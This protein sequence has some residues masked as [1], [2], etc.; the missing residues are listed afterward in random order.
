MHFDYQDQYLTIDDMVVRYWDQ[1]CGQPLLLV[2]GLG[3]CLET[4]AWNIQA[5]SAERRVIALDLPGCG[6][7]SRLLRDDIF[8]LEYAGEFLCRFAES[9]DISSLAVAGNSMGGMLAMQ[10]ALAHPEMVRLLILISS[11]GLGR[12]VHWLIGVMSVPMLERIFAHP[13]SRVVRQVALK[14]LLRQD[15][16][17]EELIRR[18]IS[19]MQVPGTGL[20]AVKMAR[21]G[22]GLL[23]QTAAYTPAQLDCIAAPTLV[24]WGE[25]DQVIPVQHAERA[26]RMIRD[27]RVAVLSQAGHGP[28]IDRPDAFNQ[29]V[30][31]FLT[32][33]KLAQEGNISRQPIRV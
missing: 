15:P 31:E 22:V 1:G 5:L 9:L 29:L 3:A 27:C 23:G 28:Q 16:D 33:G 12:E 20:A 6:K 26:L 25:E 18:V 14:I 4:W 21:V 7:S 11:G 10:F 17:S 8:S 2:H 30:L 24:I 13:S 32:T 19:Y